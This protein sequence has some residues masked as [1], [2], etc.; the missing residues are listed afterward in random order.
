MI[1]YFWFVL[2]N[3]LVRPARALGS[4]PARAFA[5]PPADSRIPPPPA[6][7]STMR[8]FFIIAA[9][10]GTYATANAAEHY[11]PVG[12]PPICEVDAQGYTHVNYMYVCD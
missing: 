3:Q 11:T 1:T 4:P 9:L 12:A 6:T 5:P 7:S 10:V 2:F 8:S